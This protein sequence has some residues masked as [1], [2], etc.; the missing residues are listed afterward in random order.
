MRREHRGDLGELLREEPA[1]DPA[2]RRPGTQ[3]IEAILREA[4]RPLHVTEIAALAAQRGLSFEG[5]AKPPVRMIQDKMYN[6]KRFKLFGR[7]H[8]GLPGMTM[9]DE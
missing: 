1:A 7:N 2:S 3:V 5:K 4:G 6:S 9:P 8:W